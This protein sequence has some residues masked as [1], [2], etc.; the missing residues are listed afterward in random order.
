M[1]SL[2]L[3]FPSPWGDTKYFGDVQNYF[4]LLFYPMLLLQ[5][6]TQTF[7]DRIRILVAS[8]SPLIKHSKPGQ[9]HRRNPHLF[10]SVSPILVTKVL[11]GLV[12]SK[13]G[14]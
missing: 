6:K 9:G 1:S 4:Y 2:C 5:I 13:F 7:T 14:I 8:I 12:V 3:G 10:V 11:S